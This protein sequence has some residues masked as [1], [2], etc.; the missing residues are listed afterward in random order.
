VIQDVDP[1]VTAVG[2]VCRPRISAAGTRPIASSSRMPMHKSPRLWGTQT[3]V[4]C[5]PSLAEQLLAPND[6]RG[7]GETAY[8]HGLADTV[9]E[10]ARR[11]APCCDAAIH[12]RV[13]RL[14]H[15]KAAL[16]PVK[17]LT[18]VY[19]LGLCLG[20]GRRGGGTNVITGS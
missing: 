13:R 8:F 17:H 9:R 18:P 3:R 10:S 12:G 1:L 15:L 19:G 5:R 6:L 20:D 16:L 14:V 7:G 2:K 4:L 11:S